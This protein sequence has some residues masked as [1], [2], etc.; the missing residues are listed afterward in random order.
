[1]ARIRGGPIQADFS[2]VNN[3][4]ITLREGLSART[5]ISAMNTIH[6][7]FQRRSKEMFSGEVDPQG[8]PWAPLAPATLSFRRSLGFPEAPINTRTGKMR[9][10]FVNAAPDVIGDG[11]FVSYAFPRRGAPPNDMILR[12]KQAGGELKGPARPVVGMSEGDAAFVVGF[13]YRSIMGEFG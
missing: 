1:M 4:L 9:D 2:D 12:L 11:A 3:H 5:M 13:M 8:T 6:Q 7:H 10:Y